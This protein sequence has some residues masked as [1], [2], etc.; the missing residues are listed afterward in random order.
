[1]ALAEDVERASAAGVSPVVLR[2]YRAVVAAESSDEAR[3]DALFDGVPGE[4]AP[5]L[6]LWRV[7]HLLRIGEASA[8]LP[9]IDQALASGDQSL[10]PY[11]ATAWR[12]TGDPR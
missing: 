9:F 11:A 12:L 6:A 10:W 8:A 5:R 7:R 4:L 3:P 2:S 1:N